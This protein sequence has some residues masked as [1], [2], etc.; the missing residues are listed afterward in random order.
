M[1]D[2]EDLEAPDQRLNARPT[3]VFDVFNLRFFE[4]PNPYLERS[5]QVFDLALTGRPKPTPIE[6]YVGRGPSTT[7]T[8]AASASRPRSPLCT[9]RLGGGPARHRVAPGPVPHP[10]PRGVSRIASPGA[11]PAHAASGDLF[12]LG[13]AR[14]DRRRR[15]VRL[16]GRHGAAAGAIQQVALWQADHLCPA[17]HRRAARHPDL[18]PAR[19]RPDAVWL[20][21]PSG[22]GAYP[23]PSRP[24]A[25]SI[26]TSPPARTIA[27]RSSA[28]SASRSQG[29]RGHRSRGGAA[30]G[31][32]RS[33]IRSR[34]SLW[35]ATRGSGSL[36]TSKAQP[37]WPRPSPV[38]AVAWMGR[39]S[40]SRPASP[41]ATTACSA[42]MAAR[43]ALDA[44][45]PGSK[46]TAGRPST[47]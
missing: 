41:A 32:R 1:R 46:A 3:D 33:A 15:A 47:S 14:G 23:P 43:R 40:S 13:L 21:P 24:T 29:R 2:G 9:Y 20:R 22:A 19:R 42:P 37:S 30:A 38:P 44:G 36:P 12:C 27:R 7:R 35:T 4:G 28:G 11:R 8:C 6:R 17:Q 16:R 25:G 18:L 39:R 45:R 34:S 26:P 31:A 5:A 10:C